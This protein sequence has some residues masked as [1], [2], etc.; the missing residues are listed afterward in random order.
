MVAR[1]SK[2]TR[3]KVSVMML[4]CGILCLGLY[5][6]SG[7]EHWTC[8]DSEA[9]LQ[10][11]LEQQQRSE[12]VLQKVNE[13]NRVKAVI[14]EREDLGT[15]IAIFERRLLGARWKY[16][17]MDMLVEN[18][19]QKEGSWH[20]VGMNDSKCEVV[21]CGDNRGG[22]IGSYVLRDAEEVARSGLEADYIIDIYI[23][24]GISELPDDFRQ[25]APDGSVFEPA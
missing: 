18:G 11:F 1:N 12:V 21:V 22:D 16:T 24:D 5:V 20:S 13:R 10:A 19:L 9:E 2:K 15:C 3:H 14:Y 7:F 8:G 4:V 25:Y 17:G 23:L 6:R